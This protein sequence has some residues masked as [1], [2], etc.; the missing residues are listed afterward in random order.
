MKKLI[1]LGLLML[2]SCK[3]KEN[4][5]SGLTNYV[6]NG[7]FAVIKINDLAAFKSDLRNNNFINQFENSA[8]YSNFDQFLSRLDY[9]EPKDHALICFTDSSCLVDEVV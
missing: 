2:V 1:L 3:Q 6:P 5:T 4:I 8:G 7:T 9:I